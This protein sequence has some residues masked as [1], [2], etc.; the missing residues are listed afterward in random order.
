MSVALWSICEIK[1]RSKTGPSSEKMVVKDKMP[2]INRL[3]K[4]G[5]II[6][7]NYKKLSTAA[8]ASAGYLCTAASSKLVTVNGL[9]FTV[10]IISGHKPFL[11]T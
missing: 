7:F 9:N 11:I 8:Q 5:N 6:M 4:R 1:V 3:V 2:I 10:L